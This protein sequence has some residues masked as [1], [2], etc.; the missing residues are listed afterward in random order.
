MLKVCMAWMST[1][2]LCASTLQNASFICPVSLL[3]RRALPNF[4][5][6]AF[7]EVRY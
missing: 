7:S 5:F 2:M 3:D 1:Q 4:A 6:T